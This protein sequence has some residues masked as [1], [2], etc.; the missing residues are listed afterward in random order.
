[1][2]VDR[3]RQ[4]G[5]DVAFDDDLVNSYLPLTEMSDFVLKNIFFILECN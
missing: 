5:V 2:R 4:K 1:M 3:I